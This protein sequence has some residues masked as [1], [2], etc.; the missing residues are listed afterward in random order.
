MCFAWA[1]VSLPLDEL[2]VAPATL[3]GSCNRER[4]TYAI[5]A[6]RTGAVAAIR[7]VG[8]WGYQKGRLGAARQL[9]GIV[10]Q[11]RGLAETE[12]SVTA[13]IASGGIST[14]SRL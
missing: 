2:D 1:T 5:G 10:R 13:S 7:M 9:A 3:A 6:P 12:G 14:E 11:L 8:G 4:K